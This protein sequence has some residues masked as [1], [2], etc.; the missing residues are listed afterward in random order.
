MT[1]TAPV[2]AGTFDFMYVTKGPTLEFNTTAFSSED[3]FVMRPFGNADATTP[4]AH[5]H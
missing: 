1:L 3:P 2:A 5:P 4:T